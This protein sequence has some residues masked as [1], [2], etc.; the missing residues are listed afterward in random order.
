MASTPRTR[1]R[2]RRGLR[3]AVAGGA[4]VTALTAATA[5][6][7]PPTPIGDAAPMGVQ[8]PGM[9]RPDSDPG[10]RVGSPAPGFL[11][12]RGRYRPVA[13]PPHLAATAPQGISPMGVNDHGQIVGEY[14]DQ[15]GV[16]HGFLLD[17]GGRFTRIDVP[18]AKGTEAIKVNNRGQIVGAYSDTAVVLEPPAVPKRS[19]LLERGR[20]TRLDPPPARSA[21][22]RSASTTAAKW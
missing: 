9:T 17:R 11:L 4:V 22:R 16:D 15:D 12:E 10:P 8:A 14:G 1:R 2:L 20:L 19:F 3:L 7:S 6:A 18:G 13:I 21:A 5:A